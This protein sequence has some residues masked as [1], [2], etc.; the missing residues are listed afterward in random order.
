MTTDFRPLF[1]PSSLAMIGASAD[2]IKDST[3]VADVLQTIP[4]KGTMSK[5]LETPIVAVPPYGHI[6][7]PFMQLITKHGMPSFSSVERAVHAL[8]RLIHRSE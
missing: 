3:L 5:P 2:T 7:Q 1:H 6:M 4:F 8:L